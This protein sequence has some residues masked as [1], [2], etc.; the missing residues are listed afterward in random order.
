MRIAI[1]YWVAAK[2]KTIVVDLLWYTCQLN[3]REGSLYIT[4]ML[5]TKENTKS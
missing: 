5:I 2:M 4:Y 1:Q 3:V